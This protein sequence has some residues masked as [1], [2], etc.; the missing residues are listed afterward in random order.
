MQDSSPGSTVVVLQLQAGEALNPTTEGHSAPVRVRLLELRSAA[1]FSRADYF[2]LAERADATLGDELVA[3][4]EWLLHPGQTRDLTRTLESETRHLGILVGYRDIDRAQ[5]RLVL[6][7]QQNALSHYRID[8]GVNAVS[9]ALL[10][11]PERNE[12]R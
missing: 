12:S 2:S 1:A 7:P 4:D 9:A 10:A 5:W 6:E 8:L 3:Q 11:R